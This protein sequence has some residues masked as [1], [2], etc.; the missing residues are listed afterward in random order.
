MKMILATL[1]LAAVLAGCATDRVV[2]QKELVTVDKPVPFI[3]KPPDVPI[4]VSKVDLLTPTDISD[5]G[6]V[7]MAYK[8]DMLALRSLIKV[9]Q[10]ILSQYANSSSNFDQVNTE[11]TG[12][13]STLNQTEGNRAQAAASQPSK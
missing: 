9:Y 4:F 11:I 3:P 12:L 13:Y 6:K 10:M 8:Y 5:P 1:V 2:I 7:G